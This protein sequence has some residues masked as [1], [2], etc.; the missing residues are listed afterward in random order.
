MKKIK[1]TNNGP[2]VVVISRRHAS[3]VTEV[4][5]PQEVLNSG[6]SGYYEI[7]KNVTI[8]VTEVS[9]S[10]DGDKQPIEEIPIE[11][12][13]IGIK[14]MPVEIK[15]PVIEVSEKTPAESID[16]YTWIGS[17]LRITKMG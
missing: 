10:L 12:S 3:A 2:E 17:K 4:V 5:Y 6:D 14:P 15:T 13:P 8:L 9:V 11:A 16:K 1:I 7:D